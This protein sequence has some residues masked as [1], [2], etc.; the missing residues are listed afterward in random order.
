MVCGILQLMGSQAEAERH[1][2]KSSPLAFK[3][4]TKE[5]YKPGIDF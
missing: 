1:C 3:E 5:V 4:P 2:G